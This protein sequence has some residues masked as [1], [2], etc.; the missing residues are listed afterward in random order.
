LPIGPNGVSAFDTLAPSPLSKP[1]IAAGMI[2]YDYTL[3]HQG[4]KSNVSCSYTQSQAPPF[5]F[6]NFGN[7][8]NTYYH[9]NCSDR[10]ESDALINVPEFASVFSQNSTLLY[11][12]CQSAPNLDGNSMA[13]YT[14]YLMGMNLYEP[15]VG[16]ITCTINSIQSPVYSVM[17]RSIEDI[18]SATEANASSPIIFS[19]LINDALVGLGKLISDSQNF[20]SNLFAETILNVGLKSFGLPADPDLPP[21]QYLSLYEQMIQ[22]IIEYEVCPI[23]YFIPFL[24]LIV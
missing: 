24:S 16:N 19:T 18:F 1:E 15:K 3:N 8:N 13:S 4:L 20:E 6:D 12:A 22:G 21:P 14:I 23:Y 9:V 5:L 10:G 17:Y 2:S 11:W 7:I